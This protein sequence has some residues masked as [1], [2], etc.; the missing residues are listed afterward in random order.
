MWE[1]VG[2]K[3][4]NEVT[5]ESSKNIW[6]PNCVQM[7]QLFPITAAA[8]SHSEPTARH[9]VTSLKH[10]LMLLAVCVQCILHGSKLRLFEY[11]VCVAVHMRVCGRMSQTAG[12]SLQAHTH[13][14]TAWCCGLPAEKIAPNFSTRFSPVTLQRHTQTPHGAQTR[15]EVLHPAGHTEPTPNRLLG[16]ASE[17][18]PGFYG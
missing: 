18:L 8:V 3:T 11:S 10:G 15:P 1:I 17:G 9:Y 5:E 6:P 13:T 2:W 16:R 7:R 14:H 4:S 12:E